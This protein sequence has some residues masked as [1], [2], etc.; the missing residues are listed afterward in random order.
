MARASF[1]L[2]RFQAG[3]ALGCNL[4]A[5]KRGLSHTGSSAQGPFGLRLPQIR[6]DLCPS[7]LCV[8]HLCA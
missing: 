3:D 7:R 1:P 8:A 5:S 6:K 4:E 2:W